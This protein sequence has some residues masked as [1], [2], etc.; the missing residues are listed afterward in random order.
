M[1][2]VVA[3]AIG[4]AD[5]GVLLDLNA[6]RFDGMAGGYGN[7]IAKIPEIFYHSLL[8]LNLVAGAVSFTG[9]MIAMGKLQ[10]FVP[11]GSVRW[12]AQRFT[13]NGLLLLMLLGM[14]VY[15]QSGHWQFAI[16]LGL[17]LAGLLF[18]VLF[19]MPIGGSD[20][21]VVISLLNSITGLTSA[22]TGI[23]FDN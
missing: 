16:I 14:I 20:M 6:E 15:F 19:V 2:I 5:G 7:S 9:S 4:L 18:G 1:L 21:P 23:I 8:M 10:G 3:E 17:C 22:L 13:N 12:P 11:G